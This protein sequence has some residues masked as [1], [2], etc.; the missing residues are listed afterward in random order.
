MGLRNK[1]LRRKLSKIFNRE[2]KPT[3]IK[4]LDDPVQ[5]DV[6]SRHFNVSRTKVKVISD[7]NSKVYPL[8]IKSL[9]NGSHYTGITND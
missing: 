8:I 4:F 9:K 7:K 5:I 6:P 1:A 3:S 2:N